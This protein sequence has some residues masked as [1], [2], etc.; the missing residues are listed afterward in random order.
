MA[1]PT[2]PT[3][4]DIIRS[5]RIAQGLKLYQ[6][7]AAANI[8]GGYLS[9]VECNHQ[10]AS[11]DV[12]DRIADGLHVPRLVLLRMGPRKTAIAA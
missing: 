8:S 10:D 9:K 2:L 7:A 1:G 12:L 6:L 5:L 3:N 11:P 4:G